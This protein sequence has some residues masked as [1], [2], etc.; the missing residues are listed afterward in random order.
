MNIVEIILFIVLMPIALTVGFLGSL[1]K[2]GRQAEDE[3]HLEYLES[4]EDK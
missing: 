1:I 4:L 3:D 2:V